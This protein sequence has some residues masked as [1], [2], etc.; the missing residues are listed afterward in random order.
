VPSQHLKLQLGRAGYP[1]LLPRGIPNQF[2]V[3]V[4][5]ARE[6]E[7]FTFHVRFEHPGRLSGANP[8]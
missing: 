5:N 2:D 1:A 7:N 4:L 6:A 8:A 3:D